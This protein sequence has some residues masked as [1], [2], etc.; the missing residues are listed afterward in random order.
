M[1]V[2]VLE[3]EASF[4]LHTLFH[5]VYIF[6]HVSAYE[7]TVTNLKPLG[8]CQIQEAQHIVPNCS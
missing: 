1:A 2:L 3:R 5:N 4:K 8:T 7:H 6:V